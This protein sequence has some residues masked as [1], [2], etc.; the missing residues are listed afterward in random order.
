[1]Y[2]Y[3]SVTNTERISVLVIS[4][5]A[6]DDVILPQYNFNFNFVLLFSVL[7]VFFLVEHEGL[8]YFSSFRVLTFLRFNIE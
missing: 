1:M 6:S 2:N 7:V 5:L 8:V 3:Y 4:S